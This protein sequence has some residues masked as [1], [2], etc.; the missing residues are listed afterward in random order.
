MFW[1]L[2]FFVRLQNEAIKRITGCS[3]KCN[4]R[5]SRRASW[6]QPCNRRI[7]TSH[8]RSSQ[9]LAV[10]VLSCK[11]LSMQTCLVVKRS[12]NWL[13]ERC[14]IVCEAFLPSSDCMGCN[15]WPA[16]VTFKLNT[17][18]QSDSIQ[19]GL[20]RAFAC[21]YAPRWMGFLWSYSRAKKRTCSL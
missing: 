8:P 2:P 17:V 5:V 20:Q 21:K 16:S 7:I 6:P 19:R 11:G 14:A 4:R 3:N 12:I 10:I 9:W 15:G 18:Q 13:T 1:H